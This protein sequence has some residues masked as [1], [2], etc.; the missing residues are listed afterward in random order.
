VF[1]DGGYKESKKVVLKLWQEIFE[2]YN[3]K[4]QDPKTKLQE[5][6]QVR[7]GDVP[8][9]ELISVTGP[10]HNPEFTVSVSFDG[11]TKKAK[12]KSRKEAETIAAK[13]LITAIKNRSLFKQ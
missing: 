5:I 9:Y 6:C 10:D 4:D 3:E 7:A 1:I 11:K 13:L 8:V 12:G 2:N